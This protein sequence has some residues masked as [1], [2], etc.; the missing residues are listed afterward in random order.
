MREKKISTTSWVTAL[1]MSFF[2]FATPSIAE[3]NSVHA[4][5]M[6]QGVELDTITVSANKQEEN[7]Q[8][9]PFS[10]TV[11][12]Q[13]DLEDRKIES[14]SNIVDYIPNISTF[15]WGMGGFNNIT[16][17]GLS[18]PSFSWFT[19]SVGMYIDGIPALGSFGY[20]TNILDIERIEVLRGPQGTLYGKNTET[21]VINIITRKAGN[22]FRGKVTIEGGSLLSAESGNRLTGGGNFSFSGPVVTDKL[23]FDLAAMYNHKDGF[24][25]YKTTGGA[26]HEQDNSYGRAKLR[27]RPNDQ[28]DITLLA[29]FLS[30]EI[31]GYKVNISQN[32]AIMFG[33]PQPEHRQIYSDLKGSQDMNI[34][35]QS[36]NVAYKINNEITFTSITSRRN[37]DFSGTS[38]NDFT[39]RPLVH[40]VQ[41][42]KYEKIS[43]E[44]RVDSVSDRLNW[45]IGAYY[46]T[47]DIE[48]N[49]VISS[50]MPQ[51]AGSSL[52]ELS[53]EA[54]AFFGQAGYLITDSFKIIAGLRYEKQEMELTGNIR[55]GT[56]DDSWQNI[57]PKFS[58]EYN[59]TSDLMTYLTVSQGFRS[60]GFNELAQDPQYFSYDP[61][62]LWSYEIGMKGFFLDKRLMVN[63]AVFY[64]DISDLQVSE[65][66]DLNTLWNTNAAKATSRGLELEATAKI[67]DSLTCNLGIGYT[68]IKFEDYSDAQGNYNGNKKPF[69]P[70]YSF[71]LGLQYRGSTGFFARIDMIGYGE[72][73][74]DKAN[75]HARDAYQLVNAKVGYETEYFDIYLYGQNI[76]DEEYDSPLDAN[77]YNLVC[78][79]PGE[80]GLQLNYRF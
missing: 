73:F 58:L 1:M 47:D 6:R 70:E 20:T 36:L 80:F 43:Q 16:S 59:A 26:G 2:A 13:T 52:T 11:L 8:D 29:S 5:S 31:D 32:G 55:A 45:I 60:G 75:I 48:R 38:D 50:I 34:D 37:S 17:R 62:T 68:N 25:E 79:E 24:T 39:P 49:L 14:I 77:G 22:K 74:A 21:G 61:E 64:M 78:S 57:S 56:L 63:T 10:I 65:R 15:D 9:I 3:E 12:S 53:G 41:N 44:L 23:F 7:V 54:Y 27:F 67:S 28:L 66:I 33:L 30:E 42:S 76:F 18:A 40:G 51:M 71:D 19:T 72:M 46:D 4:D 35:T 69:A